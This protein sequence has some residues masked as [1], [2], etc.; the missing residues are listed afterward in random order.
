MR[1]QSTKMFVRS[2]VTIDYSRTLGVEFIY[3]KEGHWAET[4][5]TAIFLNTLRTFDN[6]TLFYTLLHETMHGMITRG[7]HE[8]SEQAE[9]KIMEVVDERLAGLQPDVS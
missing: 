2:R 6:E 4:D 8:L 7:A 1:D 9:H 5:G 3:D